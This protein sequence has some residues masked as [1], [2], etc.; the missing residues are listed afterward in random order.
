MARGTRVSGAGEGSLRYP[1]PAP[2]PR[3]RLLPVAPGVYWIRMPLPYALDHINL[4]A[5]E[6]GPGWTLVDTG[7]RSAT[8]LAVWDELFAHWPDRRPPTRVIVTHLHADHVGLAGW[9]AE[10][11][12]CTLWMSRLEYQG[13]RLTVAEA[14]APSAEAAAFYHRAGWSPSAIAEHARGQ[15]RYA[16]QFHPLPDHYRRLVDGD[17]FTIGEQ[18]WRVIVGTGHSPEHVCLHCPERGLLVSGD[19]VLPR[20]TSNLSTYPREPDADPLAGWYASLARLRREVPDNVLVL[21]SHNECFYGLHARL[22]QLRRSTDQALDALREAL[23]QPRRVLDTFEALFARPIDPGNVTLLRMAT[24]EA[25]S[26]L[27]HLLRR[28]EAR[29]EVDGEGVAWFFREP[30]CQ[31]TS[32]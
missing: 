17:T 7:V 16:A 28:G 10:R 4:W 5:L 9:F 1:F 8:S 2:P 27:N 31:M 26:H 3:G 6:D 21:P 20:I 13:S 22:E 12:G 24:G 25:V 15:A 18:R 11:H 19:Q 14:G 23:V 32:Q 30:A 29:C